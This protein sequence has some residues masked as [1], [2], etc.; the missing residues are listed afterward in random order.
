MSFATLLIASLLVLPPQAATC[1]DV[2]ACQAAALEAAARKDF[3]AFHDLAWRAAQQGRRN[4]PALML[5]LARA[6]SLSGRPGDALVMLR[7]LAELGI[8]T[9]ADEDEDFQRVRALPGWAEVEALAKTAA[10]TRPA[11]GLSMPP[12]APAAESTPRPAAP[13]AAPPVPSPAAAAPAR[14]NARAPVNP[15]RGEER[16]AAA[17]EDALLLHG[18]TLD[19]VGLAYDSASRRFVLGDRSSNKLIVADEVFKQVN[20]LIGA[21][22]A[23]FGTLAGL[24]VDARRGDLWVASSGSDGKAVLH[25]LQLVSG[26]V[27][28]ALTVA[29]EMQPVR[30]ADIASSEAGAILALDRAGRRILLVQNGS[31]AITSSA[32][33]DLPDP[34]SLAPA[35]ETTAF[36]AHPGGL[37]L[38][39][40]RSG[41]TTEIAAA[42][43]VSLAGLRTIRASGNSL[44]ALQTDPDSGLD[45]LVR[46]RMARGGT[47]V[48]AIERLDAEMASA[49]AALT[50]SREAAYYVA[51][52]A[53]GPVVRRVPLH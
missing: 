34:V 25:K 18:E 17:G 29:E 37:L 51:R 9:G 32:V 24:A 6:Q 5:L 10:E 33:L 50:I 3:E 44:V 28:A 19:P 47:R 38:A 30:F 26:R 23:G 21:A 13:R 46:I 39:D 4:D 27:L 49:G 42:T 20:D 8:A 36:V 45:R 41:R 2:A 11:A 12:T 7:R 35:S 40:L 31:R 16:E 53:T 14:S 15:V 43:G 48:T 1:T 22:S 52:G